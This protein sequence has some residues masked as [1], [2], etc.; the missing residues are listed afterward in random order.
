MWEHN[1]IKFPNSFEFISKCFIFKAFAENL[2]R[3]GSCTKTTNDKTYDENKWFSGIRW[4]KSWRPS[5]S[6]Y[7]ST[8]KP[9]RSCKRRIAGLHPS[10]GSSSSSAWPSSASTASSPTQTRRVLAT[11]RPPSKSLKSVLKRH[12][13]LLSLSQ[14]NNNVVKYFISRDISKENVILFWSARKKNSGQRFVFPVLIMSAAKN[15]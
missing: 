2:N 13:D 3:T 8:K 11:W 6:C 9:W 7:P 15:T 5:R 12:K 4:K 10:P 14:V 1:E